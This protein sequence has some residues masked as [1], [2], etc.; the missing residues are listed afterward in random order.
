MEASFLEIYNESL[1]DLLGSGDASLKHDIKLV[2]GGSGASGA[3][4]VMVTNVKTVVVTSEDQVG[5]SP[6]HV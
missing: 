1:R 3:C 6:G 5:C 4:E 2:N